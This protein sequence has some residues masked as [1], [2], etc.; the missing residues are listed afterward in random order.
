MNFS[1][2]AASRDYEA[3]RNASDITHALVPQTCGG[4]IAEF[5]FRMG[6]S[7]LENNK[8]CNE[9]LGTGRVILSLHCRRVPEIQKSYSEL[10]T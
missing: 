5:M 7:L 3:Q 8:R 6:E 10:E 4:K 1:S 9:E 2:S